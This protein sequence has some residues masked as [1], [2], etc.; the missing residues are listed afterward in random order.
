MGSHS[1]WS[2]YSSVFI[3]FLY[4]LI[5]NRRFYILHVFYP[6]EFSPGLRHNKRI[7]HRVG[8]SQP[9]LPSRSTRVAVHRNHLFA[10]NPRTSV[11]IRVS[12]SSL[13]ICSQQQVEIQL[14]ISG[15]FTAILRP[16]FT[17]RRR[18]EAHYADIKEMS[19][20]SLR[21]QTESSC[22]REDAIIPFGVG[23]RSLESSFD[24]WK[25]RTTTCRALSGIPQIAGNTT[26]KSRTCSAFRT[27][28]T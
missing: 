22:F 1:G 10:R 12:L 16:V 2:L 8:S 11:S 18:C 3:S 7:D 24:W 20:R 6:P 25:T 17:I 9:V 5:Q 28:R 14:S 27:I 21:P 13:K 15:M 4:L 26:G 23:T 19:R